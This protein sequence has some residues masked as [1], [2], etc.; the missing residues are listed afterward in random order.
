MQGFDEPY[1]KK[2]ILTPQLVH[3][4]KGKKNLG[5]QE[6]LSEVANFRAD[7]LQNINYARPVQNKDQSPTR[8]TN[9]QKMLKR[10]VTCKEDKQSARFKVG[11]S[12]D[13]DRDDNANR[14]YNSYN[15]PPHRSRSDIR[16]DDRDDFG[17]GDTTNFISEKE[18]MTF[19][20][21]DIHFSKKSK[22]RYNLRLL[23][24]HQKSLLIDK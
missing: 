10:L 24:A 16:G 22:N 2:N 3:S 8:I 23:P 14:L 15:R 18:E 20:P 21:D 19:T 9:N 12:L 5:R 6:I 4:P 7:K 1:R 17:Y 11:V 13:L